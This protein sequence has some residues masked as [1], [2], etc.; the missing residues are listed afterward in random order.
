[1][2]CNCNTPD[3]TPTIQL[4]SCE[5]CQYTLN[6]D[7]VIY[8]KERLDYEAFS[9]VNNSSRTLSSIL[10]ALEGIN[11]QRTAKVIQFNVADGPI[12][13]TLVP[14]DRYKVLFVKVFDDGGPSTVT[15]TIT[16]PQTTDFINHEIIIKNIAEPLDPDT[17]WNFNF[18]IPI[19]YEWGPPASSD[20]MSDLWDPIHKTVRLRYMQLDALSGYQ[21]YVIP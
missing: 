4:N 18:N 21:W 16:L 7:C 1:M 12:T 2:A 11:N 8:N 5:G 9:V 15:F 3:C 20:D 10:T 19:Q 14:E 13:Y 6:T 17:V